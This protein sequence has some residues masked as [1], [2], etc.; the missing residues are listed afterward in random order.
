MRASILLASAFGASVFAAPASPTLNADAA[1]PS[2]L[3]TVAEY[4]NMLATKVQESKNMAAAPVCDLS[5]A[6]QPIGMFY[7]AQNIKIS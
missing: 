3:D 6:Q 7:S 5:K 1:S 4:F 2:G